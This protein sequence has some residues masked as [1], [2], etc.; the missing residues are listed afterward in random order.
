MTALGHK[1]TCRE[2][3]SRSRLNGLPADRRV[4]P[5]PLA[6]SEHAQNLL[7]DAHRQLGRDQAAVV[8][9]AQLGNFNDADALAP[10]DDPGYPDHLA[11]LQPGRLHHLAVRLSGSLRR[12]CDLWF[13]SYARRKFSHDSMTSS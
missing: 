8:D 3:D 5:T 11:R 13:E 10:A 7:N 12:R 9:R 1:R 6:G 4:D 2:P